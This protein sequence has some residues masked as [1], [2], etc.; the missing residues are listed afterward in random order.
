MASKKLFAT[1]AHCNQARLWRFLIVE[2][3]DEAL[4][5]VLLVIKSKAFRFASTEKPKIADQFCLGTAG[6]VRGSNLVVPIPGVD[7]ERLRLV[8][9][10][11]SKNCKGAITCFDVANATAS[12]FNKQCGGCQRRNLIEC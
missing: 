2:Q 8:T 7:G 1:R 11:P 12:K 4:G 10:G 6:S 3:Q 5:A 9:V